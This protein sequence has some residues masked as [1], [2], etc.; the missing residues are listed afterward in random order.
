MDV[1]A[2]TEGKEGI[3]WWWLL[4]YNARVM[5]L[6]VQLLVV[7]LAA[8]PGAPRCFASMSEDQID[9]FLRELEASGMPLRQR[10]LEVSARFV[11][12]PYRLSPLGEAKGID[13]DPLIRFD[14][15]DCTTLLEQT[16]A[17]ARASNLEE[18][19]EVLKAIRYQNG[20]VDYGARKHFM[21]AQWIPMNQRDGFLE[22]VTAEVDAEAVR[23][24]AKRLDQRV[25]SRRRRKKRYP[26]LTAEQIPEGNYRLP[27]IPLDRAR[28]LV[29]RI[30]A[31][32]V[33][34]V[35]REDYRTIP[36]RVSHQGLVVV[37][38]GRRFLRH[39]ARAG[40]G[41]V[42]DELLDTFLRRNQAY[43]KWPVVGINLQRIVGTGVGKSR[44]KSLETAAQ[45]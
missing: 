5:T 42:V 25:W 29:D 8:S 27:I 31:G 39:A 16:M 34:N 14:A 43:R 17:L 26:Q 32:C 11:G 6:V 45:P 19:H 35:V 15:V 36:V 44:S 18:A 7:L 22:D 10:V 30:P 4:W 12:V 28:G 3:A 41:R 21:M 23:W 20:V 24:V 37:R 9:A 1:N 13:P 38:R 2:G 40:Y 33:I